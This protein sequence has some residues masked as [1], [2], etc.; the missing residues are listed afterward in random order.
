[1]DKKL[2]KGVLA[3]SREYRSDNSRDKFLLQLDLSLSKMDNE[4]RAK[5][6]KDKMTTCIKN[7]KRFLG[8]APFGYDNITIKK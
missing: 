2:I 5:D 3:T 1:M 8:K 6:I 7:T 4:D